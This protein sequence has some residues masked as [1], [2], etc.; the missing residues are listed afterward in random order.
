MK[1]KIANFNSFMKTRRLNEMEEMDN[2]FAMSMDAYSEDPEEMDE[3]E[4]DPDLD[5][6]EE[7]AEEE[8]L[9]MEDLKAI[10]DDL[11]ERLSALEGGEEGEEEET[12]EAE[13]GEEEEGEEEEEEGEEI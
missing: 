2:E 10:V 9:T 4:E 11:E 12:E 6:D 5:L 8:E 3:L 7:G 1:R 13:E